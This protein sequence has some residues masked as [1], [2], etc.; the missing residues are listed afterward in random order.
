MSIIYRRRAAH[1]AV[2]LLTIDLAGFRSV[3]NF[4]RTCQ[5]FE[6]MRI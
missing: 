1:P 3:M 2:F 6:L 4:C 5:V